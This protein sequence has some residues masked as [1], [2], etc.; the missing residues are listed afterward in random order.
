MNDLPNE[1]LIIIFENLKMSP[2]SLL[3]LALTNTR[4]SYLIY[5][6]MH[7]ICDFNKKNLNEFET[8]LA[9][10][11]IFKNI[12]CIHEKCDNYKYCCK[13][14]IMCNK[15]CIIINKNIMREY[16]ISKSNKNIISYSCKE[17]DNYCDGCLRAPTKRVNNHY[18]CKKCTMRSL[19]KCINC[20]SATIGKCIKFVEDDIDLGMSYAINC[21]ECSLDNDSYVY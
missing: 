12:I 21:S 9:V 19:I 4:F 11:N 18:L 6:I 14:H 2:R 16:T 5:D 10:V 20:K 3:R 1:I 17:C 13:I 7:T 15:C 8:T